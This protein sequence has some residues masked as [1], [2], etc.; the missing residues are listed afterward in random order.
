MAWIVLVENE[1][2]RVGTLG[3]TVDYVKYNPETRQIDA[4][5]SNVHYIGRK[6]RTWWFNYWVL[7]VDNKRVAEK[8]SMPYTLK[9]EWVDKKIEL[10]AR[11]KRSDGEAEGVAVYTGTLV[12]PCTK[13]FFKIPTW[14]VKTYTRE[15]SSTIEWWEDTYKREGAY[16]KVDYNTVLDFEYYGTTKPPDRPKD[17]Q[18]K[19]WENGYLMGRYYQEKCTPTGYYWVKYKV[20]EWYPGVQV[21]PICMAELS[22]F[23]YT[24][25]GINEIIRIQARAKNAVGYYISPYGDPE[26]LEFVRKSADYVT[27]ADEVVWAEYKWKK[28][29]KN[30]ASIKI[31]LR[32]EGCPTVKAEG[33]AYIAP[34]SLSALTI[35]GEKNIGGVI[36]ISAKAFNAKGFYISPY[37]DPEYLEFVRKSA[38]NVASSDQ[39]IW[40]EYR[41]K[42]CPPENKVRVALQIFGDMF[43]CPNPKVEGYVKPCT[44][45]ELKVKVVDRYLEVGVPRALVKVTGVK[46]KEG[47][48]NI[49]GEVTF[50]DL[51]CETVLV[52]AEH[53]IVPGKEESL[54]RGEKRITLKPG[55]NEVTVEIS[56]TLLQMVTS[57]RLGKVEYY[58]KLGYA[59]SKRPETAPLGVYLMLLHADKVREKGSSRSIQYDKS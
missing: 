42:K 40:A 1:S 57:G 54:V 41:F 43:G 9:P 35:T 8:F 50:E 15:N 6:E 59:L 55:T 19:D 16:L 5:I 38:E 45:S 20:I 47:K 18:I 4:K 46:P 11:F 31:H 30:G 24:K 26:Y 34:A 29:P 28:C 21:G 23:S 27:T 52:T 36:R 25:V 37:G 32:K 3:F 14:G 10:V 48:T 22:K 53:L 2:K 39:E 49:H 56:P 17:Q 12:K 58:Y 33:V 7:Y 51:C 44:A 13:D